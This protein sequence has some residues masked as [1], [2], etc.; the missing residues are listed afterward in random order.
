ME[1]LKTNSQAWEDM[2]M[3]PNKT[4]ELQNI[5]HRAV[6]NRKRYEEVSKVNGI[7][8]YVIAAI[9]YREASFN[10]NRHLHNGDPLTKRTVQV[11]KGRPVV[12]NP[13]FTWEF[14][15]IDALHDRKIPDTLDVGIILDQLEKFNG[16]GYR[17]YKKMNSPYLWSWTN[18]YEKGK[19]VKDGIFDPE[20]VDGQCGVAL[21]IKELSKI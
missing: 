7:P 8:W 14:S 17:K 18:Q 10:F 15:A 12:G 9:H 20:F 19:Y 21:I 4:I 16:I 2:V 13:P 11:P 6:I 1:K 5:V 3:N